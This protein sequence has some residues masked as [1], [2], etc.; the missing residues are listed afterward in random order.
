[1]YLLHKILETKY[2]K[3]LVACYFNHQLRPESDQEE[4]FIE[5]L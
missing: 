3:N 1:M 2:A 5:K 4:L